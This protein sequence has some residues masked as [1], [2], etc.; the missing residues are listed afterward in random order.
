MAIK[1]NQIYCDI[2]FDGKIQ[3]PKQIERLKEC[4]KLLVL[5]DL[6]SWLNDSQLV[7]QATVQ[8]YGLLAPLIYFNI[9]YEPI[10]Q[11]RSSI[12]IIRLIKLKN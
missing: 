6:A 2:L 8:C 7:L 5:I 10:V 3:Y 11:V 9:P 4:E 1:E 12:I